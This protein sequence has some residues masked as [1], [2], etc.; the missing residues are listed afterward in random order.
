[1]ALL[2]KYLRLKELSIQNAEMSCAI[3]DSI[4][5]LQTLCLLS[6]NACKLND[7]HVSRID[8]HLHLRGI[9]LNWNPITDKSLYYLTPLRY[10]ESLT[11]QGTSVTRNGVDEYLKK[12]KNCSIDF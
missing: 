1:M 11:L 5:A 8:S 10:L 12:N 3:M 2:A 4:N 7:K 6:L 9:V